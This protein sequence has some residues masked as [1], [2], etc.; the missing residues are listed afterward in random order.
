[1]REQKKITA[2]YILSEKGKI[3]DDMK[4]IKTIELKILKLNTPV[5]IDIYGK[6]ITLILHYQEPI[7]CTVIYDEHTAT[8]FRSYFEPLWKIAKHR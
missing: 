4:N 6:N 7:S 8:T 2:K 5:G 3:Y 1:M